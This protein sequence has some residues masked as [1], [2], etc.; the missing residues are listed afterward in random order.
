M[1]EQILIVDDDNDIR[2][3]ATLALQTIGQM[4]VHS[5]ASA[6][7]ALA[8]LDTLRPDL[9]VLDVM[10]P[11]TDGASLYEMIRKMERFRDT[12]IVFMTARA[13]GGE[14]QRYLAMGAAGFIGKPFDPITLADR[15]RAILESVPKR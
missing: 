11:G 9:M 8:M 10:M 12:P 4:Q 7:E 1:A 14:I 3:I 6:Q 5:A 2:T 13:Q 15:L